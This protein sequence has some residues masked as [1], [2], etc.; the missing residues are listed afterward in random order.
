[1]NNATP[2]ISISQAPNGEYIARCSVFSTLRG[3]GKTAEEARNAIAK[4]IAKL[5][6]T[7]NKWDAISF[8]AAS[9]KAGR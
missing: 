6:A 8:L 4:K 2:H 5:L 1:M 9:R 3:Y 7:R